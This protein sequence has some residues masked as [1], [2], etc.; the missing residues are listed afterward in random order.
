MNIALKNNN[1]VVTEAVILEGKTLLTAGQLSI[2][3]D[4]II[5]SDEFIALANE[6]KIN[7]FYINFDLDIKSFLT[8][9]NENKN[10]LFCY[11]MIYKSSEFTEDEELNFLMLKHISISPIVLKSKELLSYADRLSN[12]IGS[13]FNTIFKGHVYWSH[14][15]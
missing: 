5:S 2:F 10:D 12:I 8:T 6:M 13:E 7:N 11:W 1:L 15:F 4:E 9:N 3:R 14:Q